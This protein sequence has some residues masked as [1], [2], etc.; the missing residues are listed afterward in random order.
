MQ[1]FSAVSQRVIPQF[2]RFVET[3]HRIEPV[4]FAET[5]ERDSWN[6][7]QIVLDKSTAGM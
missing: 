6:D 5:W 3:F 1:E 2:R 4:G 7:T